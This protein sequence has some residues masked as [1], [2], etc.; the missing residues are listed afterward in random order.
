MS[1]GSLSLL[2]PSPQAVPDGNPHHQ[3]IGVTG[4]MDGTM[5]SWRAVRQ[6]QLGTNAGSL[7]AAWL[8]EPC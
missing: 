6:Q 4:F 8:S 5:I 2:A 3:H 1:L 7:S